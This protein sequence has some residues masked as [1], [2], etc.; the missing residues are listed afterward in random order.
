MPLFLFL[1]GVFLRE[2][3]T[4]QA[5][6]RSRVQSLLKPYFVTLLVL[7]LVK[8]ASDVLAKRDFFAHFLSYMAGVLY[9]TGRTI[10]WPPLWYLPHIFLASC[11]GLV[12]IKLRVSDIT[13]WL[14]LLAGLCAG[15]WLLNPVDLPWSIDLL[16]IT[17]FFLVSGYLC[18]A[19]VQTLAFDFKHLVLSLVAF[20]ALH[21]FFNDTIDLNFRIYDS[22]WVSTLQALLG[23]YIC[24]SL[25]AFLVRYALVAKLLGY[26]G[27]GTL[28]ILLFHSYIQDKVFG[29][30][31]RPLGE[32]TL[33]GLLSLLVA[34]AMPLVLWELSKR[35][36]YFSALFLPKMSMPRAS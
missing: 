1:S 7:G 24:L 22:L 3:Q 8:L 25:A 20:S 14:I 26:V 32:S 12:V 31:V 23:I 2:T 28:F 34:V 13:K 29:L 9:A 10:A 36:A 27:S 15:V 11:V 30:L 16:P 18:R 19:F 35:S 17:L 33:A 5:F 21:Y 4:L 6:S